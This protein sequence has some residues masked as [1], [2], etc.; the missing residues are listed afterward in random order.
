MALAVDWARKLLIAIVA[1]ERIKNLRPL[2]VMRTNVYRETVRVNR[3]SA[4]YCRD[5]ARDL[6][7][8]PLYHVLICWLKAGSARHGSDKQMFGA[9]RQVLRGGAGRL[10]SRFAN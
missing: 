1:G 9:K 8:Q 7:G 6:I 4:R 3:C 5:F 2:A 10:R